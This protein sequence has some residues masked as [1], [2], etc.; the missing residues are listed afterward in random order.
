MSKV[1]IIAIAKNEALYI[2]EWVEHHLDLG[3]NSII[4]ADN[5]DTFLLPGI[6]D[7]PA[8]IHE[9]YTGIDK[10]QTKAYTELYNKYRKDFDWLLFIDCDEFVMLDKEYKDIQDF[11]DGF[12]SDV[13]RIN[14]KV[15]SDNDALDTIGDYRVV[16]RF[17][18]PYMTSADTFAKSFINTRVDLG[19]RKVYGHGIYDKTLDAR[20]ALGDPCENINPHTNRIVHQVCWLNHYPTKT[21][22]EYIRQKYG[23]GGANGN[24]GRYRAWESYFFRFN[25]RTQEKI[26]YANK[27]I[28]MLKN[29]Q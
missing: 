17:R 15:F 8:V 20:N 9:D 19:N 12:D 1:G 6:I 27:L 29:E 23:R 22:G 10:V 5:D 11:L 18:D 3:F 2:R 28:N 26:D 13:V 24:P 7:Y 14:W 25:R 16:E 21:I 4:I